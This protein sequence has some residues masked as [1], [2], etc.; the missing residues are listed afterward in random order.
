MK[1]G[2]F[3]VLFAAD[4]SFEEMLDHVAESGLDTVEIGT[5]GFP[6]G[7]YCDVQQLV[8]DDTKR[9]A[10]VDA[11]KRRGL[12]ISALSCHSNPLH[13]NPKEAKEAHDTFQATVQLASQIGVDTVVTFSGCPG[14]SDASKHSVWVTCPW[15]PEH[16][17]VLKW[18]WEEKAIPYWKAQNEFLGKHGVRVAIEPHPGFVVYNTE[19]MLRLRNE[20]GDNIGVNFDPSH[21][22]WQQM[23][24]LLGIRQLAAANCIFHVHAKDTAIDLY[25]TNSNGVLD[26]KPYTDEL[27]RSWIFRTVGYGHGEETWRKIV[28][29]L[30]LAGYEGAIS[31]EHEDSLMSIDEGFQKAVALLKPLVIR[32]KLDS[33][34]WA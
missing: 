16:L 15:P 26:T 34:W 30:Q 19:T 11:V 13:P 31:I 8:E 10:F 21:L 28:S 25:N 33:V 22:F 5:G 3:T 12:E 24:P 23:D 2:V 20:C 27:N 17:D 29:E 14:E 7:K 32:K 1:L 6:G 18:Q 4:K 9:N